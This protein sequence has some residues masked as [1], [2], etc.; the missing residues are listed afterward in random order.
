MKKKSV[1]TTGEFAKLCKTT[2]ETLFHYDREDLLKP[3]YVS[4]NG[5]RCYSAEQFFQFDMISVFKDTGSSLKE[6]RTFLRDMDGERLVSFLEEKNHFFK[7]EKYRLA[8]RETMLHDMIRCTRESLNLDYDTFTVQRHEEE[9]L[10]VLPTAASPLE[11]AAEFAE[12][13]AEYLDFYEKQDRLPGYPFG[14]ILAQSDV[15]DGRYLESFIFCSATPFTPAS[16][17]HIKPKGDYAVLAHQGT[18]QT[19]LQSFTEMLQ[20]IDASGL[21]IAGNAY[22]FDIMSGVLS[23]NVEVHSS[24]YCIRV[25]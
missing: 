2:K 22:V 19:H 3:K 18:V 16:Q 10:E 12:R 15:I 13:F 7:R 4:E 8:Q 9:R 14:V 25:A 17:L 11:P 21:S 1:L 23:R 5:Y 24:K 6:I 20:R